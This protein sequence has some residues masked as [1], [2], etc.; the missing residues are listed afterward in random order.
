MSKKNVS[1]IFS[2]H[3]VT[4]PPNSCYLVV[5]VYNEEMMCGLFIKLCYRGGG[6]GGGGGGR[7]GGGG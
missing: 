1:C 4:C 6:G 2:E 5:T 3:K 7:G